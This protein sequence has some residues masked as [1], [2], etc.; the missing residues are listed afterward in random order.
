MARFFHDASRG[1]AFGHSISPIPI[2]FFTITLTNRINLAF[3]PAIGAGYKAGGRISYDPLVRIMNALGSEA[4]DDQVLLLDDWVN[5]FKTEVS[6][7]NAGDN[8]RDFIN[9][10]LDVEIYPPGRRGYRISCVRFG[11][12]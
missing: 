7:S 4:N 6:K 12:S 1:S 2:D 5:N 9:V 10:L 8:E 11:S 3:V